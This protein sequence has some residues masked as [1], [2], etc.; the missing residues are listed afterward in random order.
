M[1]K[2]TDNH[3]ATENHGNATSTS[4]PKAPGEVEKVDPTT[5]GTHST[6]QT[7]HKPAK[8]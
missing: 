6:I 4:N 8:G 2:H 1:T 5:G 7:G 3:G